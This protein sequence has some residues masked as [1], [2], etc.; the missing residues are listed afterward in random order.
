MTK[1]LAPSGCTSLSQHCD[2]TVLPGASCPASPKLMPK[3]DLGCHQVEKTP[4][5]CTH[6][7]LVVLQG[8]CQSL[9]VLA[10]P[11]PRMG[12]Q[13]SPPEQPQHQGT[14]RK[15]WRGMLEHGHSGLGA[16]EPDFQAP[17]FELGCS[18]APL[19]SLELSLDAWG[20]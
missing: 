10:E 13:G 11:L 1:A 12:A 9:W 2:P 17:A 20:V 14:L 16:A 19:S 5:L 8:G 18:G 3:P 7:T 4:V 15:V 6:C